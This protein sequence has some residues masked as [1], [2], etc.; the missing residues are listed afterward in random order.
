MCQKHVV[1]IHYLVVI[2]YLKYNKRL[3]FCC[4]FIKADGNYR[5]FIYFF[6]QI[7]EIFWLNETGNY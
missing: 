2:I 4:G 6:L 5:N 1:I 3:N 7:C